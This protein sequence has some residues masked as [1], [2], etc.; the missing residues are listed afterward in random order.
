[1]NDTFLHKF[2]NVI[3]TC[4]LAT[5]HPH[6]TPKKIKNIYENSLSK[7]FFKFI[8]FMMIF[9]KNIMAWLNSFTWLYTHKICFLF[10]FFFWKFLKFWVITHF[11]NLKPNLWCKQIIPGHLGVIKHCWGFVVEKKNGQLHKIGD[12][13]SSLSKSITQIFTVVCICW[14]SSTSFRRIDLLKKILLNFRKYWPFDP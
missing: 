10:L 8:L 3:Y 14:F 9:L 4:N 1:M 13:S 5:I 2:L 7:K 6:P 11:P 12:R